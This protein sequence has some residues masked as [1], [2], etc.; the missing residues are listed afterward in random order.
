[1]GS[2]EPPDRRF[3]LGHGQ[4][5]CQADARAQPPQETHVGKGLARAG[6][7]GERV[8]R[9]AMLDKIVDAAHRVAKNVG[10]AAS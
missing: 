1:V 9:R 7:R 3:L 6:P 5:A 8:R 10:G 4:P 2:S